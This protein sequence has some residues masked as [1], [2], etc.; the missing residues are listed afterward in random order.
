MINGEKEFWN[1]KITVASIPSRVNCLG[2]ALI[3]PE[4]KFVIMC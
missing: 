3:R 1:G 2:R 4:K